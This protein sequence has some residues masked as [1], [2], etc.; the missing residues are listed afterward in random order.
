MARL[1]ERLADRF[2][3]ARAAAMAGSMF[4]GMVGVI[5][6]LGMGGALALTAIFHRHGVL[7]LATIFVVFRYTGMLQTPVEQLSK[8]INGLQQATGGI[9]RIRELL[10]T[11]PRI[12]DGCQTNLPPGPLSVEL[13]EVSFAYESLPVLKHISLRLEPGQVLGLLGRTG[14]GKTTISRLLFRLHDPTAGSVHLGSVDARD[15]RLDHL[16]SRV[17]L[18]TQD[19]QLF[20]GTVRDNVTLFDASVS[21]E[22]VWMTFESLGLADWMSGL[23]HGIDTILGAGARGLSAGEAQLVALA[24]IFLKDPGL[25]ILDEASSRLD[26]H[27]L[28]LVERG[29][30]R[31]LAGRSG[32][33]IAHR[34][35]TVERCDDIMIL[36]DGVVVEYGPA[37]ELEANPDS[38]FSQLRRAGMAEVLA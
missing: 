15:L 3:R 24:R 36:Q 29:V 4:N 1:Q 7:T 18:V 34:L 33:V 2:Y 30:D 35:E 37:R 5:F 6:A 10:G 25:I 27:T 21:D 11:E 16:R 32:V 20:H 9:V 38:R 19:V 31:L 28:R 12:K 13:R 23:P 26:P 8:Q 22:A 17:G 14:S